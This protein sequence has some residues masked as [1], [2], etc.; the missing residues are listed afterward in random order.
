MITNGTKL[1]KGANMKKSILIL[2]IIFLTQTLFAQNKIKYDIIAQKSQ[3]GLA[4]VASDYNQSQISNSW[5]SAT[6]IS[7]GYYTVGTTN[8]LSAKKS[9]DNCQVTFGHP[10]AMTSYALFGIDGNW[11]KPDDYL[12]VEL[13]VNSTDELKISSSES[14]LFSEEFSIKILQD[15]KSISLTQKIKNLDNISHNFGLGFVFDPALGHWGD[16]Y[17]QIPG[18]FLDQDTTFTLQNATDLFVWEKAAGAKGIGIDLMLQGGTKVIAGNWNDLYSNAKPEFSNSAL[19]KIYDLDLKFYSDEV[20]LSPGGE[21]TFEVILKLADPDFSSEIFTRW[22]LPNYL[23]MYNGTMFPRNMNTYIE[24]SNNS[25]STL[26]SKIILDLPAG[27]N[28]STKEYNLLLD[29]DPKFQNINLTSNITYEDKIVQVKA[30]VKESDQVVDIINRNVFIPATPVSDTGLNVTIDT[31]VTSNFPKV[32]FKFH[33]T[34]DVTKALLSNLTTENVFLYEN[35]QRLSGYSFSIDTTGGVKSVDIIFALDVTGS[36]GD[37]IG[38]VKDNII[39]FADSLSR[40]GVDYRLGMITFLDAIENIYQFTK[41]VQ[42]FQNWASQQYAHGGDDTPENSLAALMSASEFSFRENAK[43]IIIWIT[44]ADFHE[45]DW[46]TQL[47]RQEVINA[48]LSKDITVNAIGAQEYKTGSYDPIVNA[49]G[50]NYY[51][52]NGNFRDI[53]LDIGRFKSSGKYIVSYVSPNTNS[54]SNE[55][56]LEIRYAGL[57]GK[58]TTNYYPHGLTGTARYFKFYPNPFNPSIT[59]VVNNMDHSTGKLRI[60]NILGQLVKSFSIEENVGNKIIWNARNEHG[61]EVTA[62]FYIVQ[63]SLTDANKITRSET[64]KILYLK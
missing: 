2:L 21:K 17:L 35:S 32:E 37:E 13:P 36:M 51:D 33:V 58:A 11:H 38:K 46:A 50:G 28:C 30:V 15:G 44:D 26:N 14:G 4:K 56:K 40:Q 16:G 3:N 43:R 29:S 41:D 5:L 57:G 48:L 22:D 8:G 39:E 55:L 27:L 9:D 24:L 10:F 18:G 42:V 6:L 23:D 63:L 62:G 20:Q 53:L 1:Y 54:S 52:I 45:S 25:A 7:G 19:R 60:Y 64:A 49:T 31:L 12:P 34:N 47:T 61:S 59:F